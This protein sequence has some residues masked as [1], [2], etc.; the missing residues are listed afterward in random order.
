MNTY[1][2]FES[3][4]DFTGG[5]YKSNIPSNAAKKAANR[6][7][8]TTNKKSLTFVIRQTTHGTDKK[9]YKYRAH[10]KELDKPY[11]VVI[12][13]KEIVYKYKIEVEPLELVENHVLVHSKSK[14]KKTIKGGCGG[15]SQ[16]SI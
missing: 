2:V 11:V 15:E 16:C 8:R 1:T 3:D 10:R 13:G 14:S 12:K 5:R 6:M 4:I 9:L 7:F